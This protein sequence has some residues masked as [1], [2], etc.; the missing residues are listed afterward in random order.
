MRKRHEQTIY[1]KEKDRNV[2]PKHKKDIE[3]IYNQINADLKMKY[4]SSITLVKI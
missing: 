1:Q 2:A 3:F 4:F